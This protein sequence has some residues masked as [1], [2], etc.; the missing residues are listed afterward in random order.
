[1]GQQHP[2]HIFVALGRCMVQRSQAGFI[3]GRGVCGSLNEQLSDL[4]APHS[5]RHVEG[6]QAVLSLRV[7]EAARFEQQEHK[8]ALTFAGRIV[9]WGHPEVVSDVGVRALRELSPC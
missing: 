4:R 3:N 8:L 7:D 2:A 9:K 1:V 5:G 6:R